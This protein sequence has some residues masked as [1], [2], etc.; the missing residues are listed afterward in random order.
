MKKITEKYFLDADRYNWIIK[1]KY[2]SKKNN[3]YEFKD[4]GYWYSLGGAGK[5]LLEYDMKANVADIQKAEELK[6]SIFKAFKNVKIVS[7]L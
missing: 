3:K 6:E 1:E 7:N 4:I 2:F 5:A